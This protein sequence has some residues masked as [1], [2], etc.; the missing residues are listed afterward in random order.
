MLT[1][2]TVK[3]EP[4]KSHTVLSNWTSEDRPI[5]SWI[6]DW[7]LKKVKRDCLWRSHLTRD[8]VNADQDIREGQG[9][10][11]KSHT[12][13]SCLTSAE[14]FITPDFVAR[15]RLIP[16]FQKVTFPRIP[17]RFFDQADDYQRQCITECF[18]AGPAMKNSEAAA[19]SQ[20][21][22]PYRRCLVQ[23]QA[24]ALETTARLCFWD[25]FAFSIGG[26]PRAGVK[27]CGHNRWIV[28][29]TQKRSRWS[30]GQSMRDRENLHKIL[31]R[32]AESSIQ[33]ENEAQKNYQ[34]IEADVEITR[35][36]QRS[37]EIALHE[38]YRE[39][40]TQ[41]L[42]LLQ[43]NLWDNAQSDRI[44]LCGELGMRNNLFKKSRTKDCQEIEELRRRCCEESDRARQAKLDELSVMQQ[45]D[46]Q[47]VS[48]LLAQMRESQDKVNSLS[49]AREFHDPETASSSGASHVTSPPLT[50]PSLQNCASPRFW[51]AAWNTQYD[52]IS[53]VF[54]RLPAR[55]GQPQN[56][57]KKSRNLASSS[58]GVKPKLTE[59]T[60]TTGSKR[61]PKQ[62]DLSNSRNFLHC[63][64]GISRHTGGTY[65]H[66]GM[67]EY[68]RF[69]ISELH[70]AKFPDSME[71]G[72]LESQFQD[73]SLC[74]DSESSNHDVMDHRSWESKVNWRIEYIEIN[75]WRT[76]IQDCE[77][78]DVMIASALKK[79][80]NSHIQFLK[81]ICVEEQRAQK[82]DRFLRGR[83][84]SYMICEHF[85]APSL[86][87]GTR[88]L[89]LV[90]Y[91]SPEWWCPRFSMSD[92]I[93]HYY[94]QMN[95]LTDKVLEGL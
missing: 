23:V 32:E 15:F 9:I 21:L 41:R 40:E 8:K 4:R 58:R 30:V 72:K 48:Q 33:G 52:G 19:A 82:Y 34:K 1:S 22:A 5:P 36:E 71:F 66:G 45:R 83:Q 16:S 55:E 38:S 86:W 50:N 57:S 17:P 61:R 78:L 80:V 53:D 14:S 47:T 25:K 70:L 85:H 74:E 13:L 12:V 11:E 63:G 54:E 39:L 62:Q 88:T 69:P 10:S 75:S 29:D 2:V 26:A 60:M 87:I 56:I 68:P 89:R 84:I 24:T 49:D 91:T 79:I 46:P 6:S 64:D 93:R 31:E 43:E 92:G 77:M 42:Q 81:R 44:S 59:H 28:D 3:G 67:M 90:H 20:Q 37:S 76:D 35:W 95:P 7:L 94:Q 18:R 65:S 73:W 51:I 27:I